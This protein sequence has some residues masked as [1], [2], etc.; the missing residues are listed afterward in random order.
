MPVDAVPPG[1]MAAGVDRPGSTPGS[2]VDGP[3]TAWLRTGTGWRR[4][5][6]S[7]YGPATEAERPGGPPVGSGGTVA[8]LT[9]PTVLAALAG[10]YRPVLHA[11]AGPDIAETARP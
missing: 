11:T 1:A 8:L 4:W 7:G 9:P 2:T 5:G 3:A 6:L 10:G